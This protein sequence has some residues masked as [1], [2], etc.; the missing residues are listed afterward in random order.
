MRLDVDGL[1]RVMRAAA[2]ASD[3]FDDVP[4]MIH[5][6]VSDAVK[7]ERQSHSYANRTGDAERLTTARATASGSEANMGVQYASVLNARGWS[8]FDVWMAS[9][10][11]EITKAIAERS[12]QL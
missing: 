6:M 8:E 9:A 4:R 2:D 12:E 5:E 7:S 3:A 1:D 11:H 10:D